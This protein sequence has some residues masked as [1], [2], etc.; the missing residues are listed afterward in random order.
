MFGEES[1]AVCHPG[2]F[3]GKR[4]ITA[5]DVARPRA[6]TATRRFDWQHWLESAGLDE[7][8]AMRGRASSITAW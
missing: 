4:R 5:L 8:N 7:V 3:G 6:C 1:V 2:F